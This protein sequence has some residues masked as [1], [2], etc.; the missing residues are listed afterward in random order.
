[1]IAA[2]KLG[3]S[4]VLMNT[5]FAGTQLGDVSAREGVSAVVFDQEFTARAAALPAEVD[6][7]LAWVDDRAAIDGGAVPTLEELITGTPQTRLPNPPHAGHL[8]MLTSGTTGTPKGAPRRGQF[9]ARGGAVLGPHPLPQRRRN[10]PCSP[11]VS[12]HRSV[13]ADLDGLPRVH[14]SAASAL[15]RRGGAAGYSGQ[16]VHGGGHG[17]HDA[18][19]GARPWPRRSCPLRHLHLAHRV[20]RGVGAVAGAGE[21]SDG[22]VRRRALQPVRLHRGRGGHRRHA[23]RLESRARHRRT[24]PGGLPRHALRRARSADRPPPPARPGVRG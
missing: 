2:G 8:V 10:V 1:M 6:R 17:A 3:A 12:R 21:S 18:A 16:P 5:G 11:G 13:A 20:R 24:Y 15:R 14:S 22:G 19:A 7:Y 4:V 9:S 23:R